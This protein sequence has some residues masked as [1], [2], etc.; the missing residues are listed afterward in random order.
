MVMVSKFSNFSD[1]LSENDELREYG[2]SGSDCIPRSWNI[3]KNNHDNTPTGG[4]GS[5]TFT[6][7]TLGYT[8]GER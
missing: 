6:I 2:L 5:H 3:R 7:S 8:E 4:G 1:E